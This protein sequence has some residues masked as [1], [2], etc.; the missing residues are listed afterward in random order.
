MS[1]GGGEGF[2][3]LVRFAVLAFAVLAAVNGKGGIA[4]AG[5]VV[6]FVMVVLSV[7]AVAIPLNV[8][9]RQREA[10]EAAQQRRR[11]EEE[12]YR[13][14]REAEQA[15]KEEEARKA[16]AEAEKSAA[17]WREAQA[18]KEARRPAREALKRAVLGD[19]I[20]Q[21]SKESPT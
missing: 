10:I 17:L 19:A 15:A 4:T 8:R 2:G 1:S 12:H 9:R 16:Q 6:A 7:L 21:L 5:G 13:R 3:V 11:D 20:D 14:K 18:A